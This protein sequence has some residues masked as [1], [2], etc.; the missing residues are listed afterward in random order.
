[1]FK[2]L[3]IQS[4][5]MKEDKMSEQRQESK[6]IRN[7]GFGDLMA[8]A[9][10]QIVGAG[11]MSSTG[12]AIGMTGTGVFLAFGGHGDFNPVFCH[13]SCGNEVGGNFK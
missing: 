4:K 8:I 7:L 3:T 6:L 11:I 13:E 1:M 9:I 12:V 2:R 10:G 5:K